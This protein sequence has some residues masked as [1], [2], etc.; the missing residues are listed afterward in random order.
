[1]REQ[2]VCLTCRYWDGENLGWGL[3][4][5]N[6]PYPFFIDGEDGNPIYDQWAIWPRTSEDD[7]CFNW[8]KNKKDG[9]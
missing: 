8:K 7:F 5:R 2:Q 4:R 1:M 9:K 6:A 3:C